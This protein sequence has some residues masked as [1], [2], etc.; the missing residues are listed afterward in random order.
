MRPVERRP[1]DPRGCR[2]RDPDEPRR[3]APGSRRGAAS[4]TRRAVLA[5]VDEPKG[6]AIKLAIGVLILATRARLLGAEAA[7]EGRAPPPTYA[8]AVTF[9]RVLVVGAGQ[10]GAGI[11]QV[12]AASGRQVLLH[13]PFPGRSSAAS[14]HAH[15]PRAARGEGRRA[16]G[17]DPRP[18][19]GGRRAR[20]RRPHD[21][22]DRR[23]RRREG[24]ALPRRRHRA[25]AGGDPRLQHL[26]DPDHVAGRRHVAP[27]PRDRDALLQPRAGAA[28]R[29]GDP[30]PADLRRDRGRDRRPR[31][32]TSARCRQRRT[33]TRASS[34]TG[35]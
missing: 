6:N 15:E 11:A 21:R 3:R 24:G 29:G 23:G 30:R 26:L 4:P 27:R 19:H 17:R 8:P 32:R 7:A 12:V 34:P 25:A 22:G 14:G 13:D 18:R 5:T 35:S 28:A 31:A 10:M 16:G 9:E 20:A 33:T 1:A 2:G